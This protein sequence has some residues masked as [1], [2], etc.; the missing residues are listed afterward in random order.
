MLTIK[1][2][3]IGKKNQPSYRVVVSER[4]SKLQGRHREDL[5]WYNPHSKAVDLKEDRIKH[6]LSVG[7]QP[8]NTIHNLFVNKGLIEGKKV[9]SHSK[10]KKA[11]EE[12]PVQAPV[13]EEK[14]E[15]ATPAEEPAQEQETQAEPA[16]EAPAPVEEEKKEEET[17]AE[18][19]QDTEEKSE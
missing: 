4:G 2:R 9:S 16:E 15:E 19:K 10:S 1:F 17:P 3:R 8:S 13:A 7:A 5:G 12:A 6:W 18:A 11:A 14:T